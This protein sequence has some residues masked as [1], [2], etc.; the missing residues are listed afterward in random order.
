MDTLVLSSAYQPLRA[1][2]WKRAMGLISAGKVE[3]VKQYKNRQ[4]RT[5][6]E[7]IKI[8]SIIRFLNK[9]VIKRFLHKKKIP[10]SKDNIWIRDDG[11]CQYCSKKLERRKFTLD[12]VLPISKGG[13]TSWTNI[14]A[15]CQECNTYKRDM[16]LKESK[17]K[18]RKEP[19]RPAPSNKYFKDPAAGLKGKNTHWTDFLY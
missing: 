15:C 6:H 11:E 7:T 12:H 14:V 10:Y 13:K 1:V 3:V 17:M 16:T 5:A 18:L 9:E 8:P 4:I 19:I 2:S